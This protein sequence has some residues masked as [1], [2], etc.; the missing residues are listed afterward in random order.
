MHLGATAGEQKS[1]AAVAVEVA[2]P[3]LVADPVLALA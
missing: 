1:A 3:V 2:N